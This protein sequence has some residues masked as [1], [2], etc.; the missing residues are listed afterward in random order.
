LL[1]A[2]FCERSRITYLADNKSLVVD[3]TPIGF[4]LTVVTTSGEDEPEQFGTAFQHLLFNRSARAPVLQ[5][6]SAGT[7][8]VYRSGTDTEFYRHFFGI[9]ILP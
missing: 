4:E 7:L 2:E 5:T 1:L 9:R 3:F 6:K 8:P